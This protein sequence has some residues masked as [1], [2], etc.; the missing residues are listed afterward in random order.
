MSIIFS[1][2]IFVAFCQQNEDNGNN[3]NDDDFSEI[4]VEI[5]TD[6]SALTMESK[7]DTNADKIS[8]TP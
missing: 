6:V 5:S 8:N 3:N 2:T 7:L 1:Y 4:K